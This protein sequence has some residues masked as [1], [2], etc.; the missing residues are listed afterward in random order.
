MRLVQVAAAAAVGIAVLAGC[1][2]GE[3]ANETLPS[4]SSSAAGTAASLPPLGPPDL[5]MPDE[6]REQTP[7]GAEAFLRY[8]MAVYTKAQVEMDSTY[9][10][11][12]S[13]ECSFCD[14]LIQRLDENAA[15]RHTY[16]G[17]AVTLRATSLTPDADGAIEGAFTIDQA[18]L[19]IHDEAGAT[20]SEDPQATYSCGAVLTWRPTEAAWAMTQWDVN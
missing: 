2:G 14:A 17:G 5:P 8:Y 9:L 16:D 10:R 1:S 13:Q 11:Q 6:A 19:T 20:V 15:S 7:A 18:A 3:T 12:F 4:T